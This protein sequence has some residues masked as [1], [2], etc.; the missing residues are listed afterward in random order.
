MANPEVSNPNDFKVVTFKNGSDF[1]FTPMLGCMYDGRPIFGTSG[2]SVEIGESVVLPYHVGN[3]VAK[4]LAKA[5]LNGQAPAVDPKGNPVGTPLWSE[6][7]LLELKQSFI[8]DMYTEEKP[9]AVTETDRL[10][11]KV[12]EYK[13]MVDKLIPESE[14]EDAPKEDD[15]TDEPPKEDAPKKVEYSDKAEVIAE[16]NKREISFNARLSKANLE[17]LLA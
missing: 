8:T 17:K 6:T 3:L 1:D 5:V 7:S 14:K 16:L 15:K 10:M 11:A 13:A 2:A 12:E 4:N 9:V